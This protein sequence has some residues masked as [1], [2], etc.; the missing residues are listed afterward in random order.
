MR[1]N[2]CDIR[3]KLILFGDNFQ[4]LSANMLFHNSIIIKKNLKT[5]LTVYKTLQSQLE[6]IQS[7][8]TVIIDKVL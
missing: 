3:F 1:K 4:L 6:Y 5:A 7:D 8:R 2:S